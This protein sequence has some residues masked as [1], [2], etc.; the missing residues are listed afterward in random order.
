MLIIIIVIILLLQYYS[1]ES[2]AQVPHNMKI[3]KIQM[4]PKDNDL[5]GIDKCYPIV[6][7]S[8][9]SDNKDTICLLC[10][11]FSKIPEDKSMYN[12]E[13]K[14]IDFASY[15]NYIPNQKRLDLEYLQ[16]LK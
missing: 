4:D 14:L 7:P 1:L 5:D 12:D 6:C 11:K 9:V 2:F 15:F 10:G 13:I 8:N 3:I 16:Y